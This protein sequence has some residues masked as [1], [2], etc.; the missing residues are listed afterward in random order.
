MEQAKKLI[1]NFS[2]H[3][4]KFVIKTQPVEINEEKN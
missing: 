1:D 2:E 3:L 4:Q